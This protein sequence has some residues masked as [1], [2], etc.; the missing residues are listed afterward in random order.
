MDTILQGLPNIFVYLDDILVA[1]PSKETHR[2]HLTNL[3]SRL[4]DHGLTINPGKCQLGAE[5]LEFLG[6]SIN[7][8]GISPLAD[9]VRAVQ[10]YPPPKQ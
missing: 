5:S 2:L 9:K 8:A 7:R 6:H 3:F 4:Q 10:D 1:S